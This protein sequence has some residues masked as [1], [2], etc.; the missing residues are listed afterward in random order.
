MAGS[1]CATLQQFAALRQVDFRLASVGGGRLAGVDVSRVRSYSD[2]SGTDLGRL[3]LA[4]ARREMP[5]EFTVNIEGLNPAENKVTAR[6]VRL[7][8]VLLLQDKETISGV[9]D[10]PIA[11]PPGRPAIIP[12]TMQLDLFKFFSGSARDLVNIA[13]DAAGPGAQGTRV[14]LRA[15]PTIDTPL[16]RI[17]YPNPITIVS[18]TFGGAQGAGLRD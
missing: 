14:S 3:A 10:Q 9:I 8:W 11:F 2:L 7:Q 17:S 4:A 12:M 18:R 6:M 13:L 15:V 1:G 16:G 5:L